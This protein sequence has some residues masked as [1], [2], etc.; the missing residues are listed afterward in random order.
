M[1]SILDPTT[2]PIFTMGS[3]QS[4]PSRAGP[5]EQTK[6]PTIILNRPYIPPT[7]PP[8]SDSLRVHFG[9]CAGATVKGFP[10]TGG[11][12]RLSCSVMELDF[13]GVDRFETA[14]RSLDPAE[15]DSFCAKMRLLGARWWPSMD[16]YRNAESRTERV[17]YIGVGPQGGV[18]ALE[19]VE[20]DF[21]EDSR[22]LGRINNARNMEEKC[23]EIERFGGTFY[24]DL[25][26]C[27]LLD[28]NPLFAER[29]K[30]H[31]LFVDGDVTRQRLAI[32]LIRMKL[33]FQLTTAGDS[34]EAS[35][36]LL[37]NAAGG[38]QRNPAI[39]LVDTQLPDAFEFSR[40][41]MH[42]YPYKDFVPGT[43][44]IGM[45][46]SALDDKERCMVAGMVDYFEHPMLVEELERMLVRWST[47]S[48]R[49]ESKQD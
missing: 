21:W 1:N 6:M 34:G 4:V 7:I 33:G 29:A 15:E 46:S 27:P 14:P 26:D 12:Y 42:E 19:S 18:W 24:A 20:A 48:S 13:L 40:I 2:K 10:S 9:A 36:Y 38:P 32:Q 16:A 31:I 17:H 11:V 5:Q 28:F 35:S 37:E 22:G 45:S 41:I 25:A 39:I 43:P 30:T 3:S 8:V 23:R 44:I 47:K 49:E